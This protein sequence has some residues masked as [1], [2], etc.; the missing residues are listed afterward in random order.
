MGEAVSAGDVAEEALMEAMEAAVAQ[1]RTIKVHLK[2]TWVATMASSQ[3][4]RKIP[5]IRVA[6]TMQ[7]CLNS[8][9][10]QILPAHTIRDMETLKVR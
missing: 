1:P 4:Q 3:D 5:T 2:A 6:I 9:A 8:T 7:T 10:H